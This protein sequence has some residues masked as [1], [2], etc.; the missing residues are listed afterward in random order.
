MSLP[1]RAMREAGFQ[2][3]CL[4]CDEPDTE[5]SRRCRACIEHHR[6][7]RTRLDALPATDPVRHLSVE[8][9]QML[10]HPE[11]HDHDPVHRPVL[12]QYQA[13][14]ATMEEPRHALTA[15]EVA[16]LFAE[17]AASTPTSVIR[18]L[19]NRNTGF[20]QPLSAAEARAVSGMMAPA[21]DPHAG[22]RT[23]PSRPIGKVD[24]SVRL[25]EDRRTSD[26]VAAN[27]E[28]DKVSTLGEQERVRKEALEARRKR[29]E[30]WDETLGDVDELLDL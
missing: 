23:V 9:T 22:A 27:V 15:E 28:A 1:R 13:L 21:Q 20:D 2:L 3:C 7:V 6:G 11:E 26:L 25:G 4:L 10:A 14:L 16:A 24:R 19:G 29:R 12:E 18:E 8:L 5:G 30:A 17:A